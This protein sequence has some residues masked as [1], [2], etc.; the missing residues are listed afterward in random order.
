[1][2][3]ETKTRIEALRTPEERF[4]NIP[5]W[6]YQP[7]YIDDLPGYEGLRLH[8]IDEGPKTG[9]PT[10][11]CLHGEPSWLYLFRK[12]IPTFL[13]AGCRVVGMDWF[14]FG[15]SDKPVDDAAYTFDFHRNSALRFVERLDLTDV[16]PVLQ[17]WGG[18]LGLTLPQEAPERYTRLIVMNT[19][20]GIGVSPGPGFDAW[21]E[22]AKSQ[23][24]LAVGKLMQQTTPILTDAERDAYDAPFPDI[25][26]KAGVRAFPELV[27]TSP[28][29]DGVEYGKRAMAF[30]SNEWTGETFMA[31]GMQDPVLTP[32]LMHALKNVIRGCREPMEVADAGHFVQEWGEPIAQAA[33]KAFGLVK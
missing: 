23:P 11:L 1:M 28:E 14:G 19:G 2:T 5:D 16:C 20:I 31:I 6:P 29:M 8:Y 17:D 25:T 4:A 32:A 33:V 7:R 18:L 30:W 10:M 22:Y 26:Y 27:C 9:A 13:D 21:R 15:R 12:M 24:D 3:A